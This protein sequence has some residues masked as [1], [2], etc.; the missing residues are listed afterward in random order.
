M[1]QSGLESALRRLNNSQI[2][3]TRLRG[4]LRHR[5]PDLPQTEVK[6]GLRSH[7]RNLVEAMRDYVHQHYR[8][9]ISLDDVASAMKMN[10]SYLCA[11]FSKTTGVTFH[12][13]LEEFRLAK[14]KELLRDP[15]SLVCEV[16]C[17]VGYTNPNHFR[18]VFK[19]R[20]GL[21]PSVWRDN[22]EP[23]ASDAPG[24]PNQAVAQTFPKAASRA[25]P[26][27]SPS[28]SQPTFGPAS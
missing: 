16:A 14:A 17:T 5:L 26:W 4:E 20:T 12:Q 23:R 18:N 13:Y 11:L 22:P 3:A 19:A 8:R 6:S 9:P 1:A 28:Q 10:A 7:A 2:E 27:K 21:A 24:E 25:R 15:M